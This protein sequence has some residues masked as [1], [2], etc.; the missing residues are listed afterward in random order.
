MLS[1]SK[2][3]YVKYKNWGETFTDKNVNMEN[4]APKSSWDNMFKTFKTEKLFDQVNEKLSSV[5]GDLEN[6]LMYPYPSLVFNAFKMTDFDKLKVV[7]IGQDPYFDHEMLLNEPVPQAMGLSFSVPHGFKIPSSLSNIYENL[8]HF[9]HIQKKPTHGNLEF[10]AYQGCL[11]LNTSLTV[12]DGSEN[13]NCHQFIWR[14]FT[15]GIIKYIS[16]NCDNVIFVA[17]GASAYEKLSLVDLDKHEAIISTHPSGLS[18][19]KTMKPSGSSKEYP[20]FNSYDH[21]GKINSILKRWKKDPIIW[22][23]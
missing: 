8:V 11:M 6:E 20:S 14:K 1:L 21:F 23:I 15:D 9:G 19:N 18:A 5:L 2:E 12:L 13:K 3:K 17:W 4:F 7:F 16:N 22:N 10:W